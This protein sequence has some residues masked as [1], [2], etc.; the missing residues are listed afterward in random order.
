MLVVLLGVNG[1]GAAITAPINGA[2]I[3]VARCS[4]LVDMRKD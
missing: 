1:V 4:M 2:M 3:Y